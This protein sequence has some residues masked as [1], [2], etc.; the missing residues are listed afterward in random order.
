MLVA[1][2]V[3]TRG[4]GLMVH[5]IQN[6]KRTRMSFGKVKEVI[7]MTNLIEVQLDS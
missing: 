6:G 3:Y 2:L 7:D 1:I 5:P 4:E